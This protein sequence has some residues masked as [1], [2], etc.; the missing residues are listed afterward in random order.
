MDPPCE[1][2]ARVLIC[3]VHSGEN[4]RIC[5]RDGVDFFSNHRK[6]VV[7][8]HLNSPTEAV[9]KERMALK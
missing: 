7:K 1:A 6:K 8:W 3:K 9:E 2:L 5:T 4:L